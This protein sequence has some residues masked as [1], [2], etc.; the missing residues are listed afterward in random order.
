MPDQPFLNQVAVV[1]DATVY[2]TGRRVRGRPATAGRAREA[3]RPEVEVVADRPAPGVRDDETLD[4]LRVPAREVE[5]DRPAPVVH[6]QGDVAKVE[7]VEQSGQAL[8]VT[9][10]TMVLAP[11]AP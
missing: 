2:C 3:E 8:R 11:C 6:E 1:A 9:P 4:A 10:G 7:M 5:A